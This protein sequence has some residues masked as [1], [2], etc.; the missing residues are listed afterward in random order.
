MTKMSVTLGSLHVIHNS[1]LSL[2]VSMAKTQATTCTTTS[3]FS[4]IIRTDPSCMGALGFG[5]CLC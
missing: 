2:E 4:E 5:S 1:N 3:K